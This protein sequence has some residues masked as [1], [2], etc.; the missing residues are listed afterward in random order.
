MTDLFL[1]AHIA[2]RTVAI[3]TDQVESVVDIG[4]ITPV[5]GVSPHV[6]GLAALRS[7]VV[8][9]ISSRYALGAPVGL[10]KPRRAILT[11]LDGHHYAILVNALEDVEQLALQPLSSGLALTGTWREAAIGLV[12][13]RG[14]PI[15]AISLRALVPG[16]ALAA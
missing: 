16:L 10:S 7:R 9:V 15:L 2:D 6:R 14:E 11:Q 12:D 1:I 5:P 8:T 3:S 13:Y 4:E